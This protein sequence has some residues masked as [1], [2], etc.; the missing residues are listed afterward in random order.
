MSNLKEY[1]TNWNS[2]DLNSAYERDLNIL[3]PYSFDT[4][5]LEIHCNITDI[6]ADTVRTQFEH[7]LQSKIDSAREIFEAN[8]NNITKHALKDKN[9]H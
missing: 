2:I 8:L 3:D 1:G 9:S 4:L 6:N 7:E 5:L